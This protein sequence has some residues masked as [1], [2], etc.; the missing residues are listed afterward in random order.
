[1]GP[2]RKVKNRVFFFSSAP[3]NRV[4][5]QGLVQTLLF[6]PWKCIMGVGLVSGP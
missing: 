5:L 4:F 2:T 1:M 6:I 3:K